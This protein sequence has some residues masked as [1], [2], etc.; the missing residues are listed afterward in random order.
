M[1]LI[2]I[3]LPVVILVAIIMGKK[4]PYIGGKTKLGFLLGG[5]CALILGG[6]MNPARW[7]VAWFWQFNGVAFANF[8]IIIG[9]LFAS[10]VTASG[11]VETIVN[12]L[13]SIFGRSSQG[14]VLVALL[15]SFAV[16]SMVG[17][18][19]AIA[20]VVGVIMIPAMK[21]LK[22]PSSLIV[23]I[24]VCGA[25]MG[26]IMPPVS[27][28][29]VQAMSYSGLS[30]DSATMI[31]YATVAVGFCLTSL[32]ICKI[33]VGNQYHLDASLIPEEKAGA[34][35]RREWSNLIPFVV[36]I[37]MILLASLPGIKIDI[38][39]LM[40]SLI[41]LGD[42]NLYTAWQSIPILGAATNY[43]VLD[44]AVACICCVATS[45]KVRMEIKNIIKSSSKSSFNVL[46]LT[47]CMVY[48]V[49]GYTEG[50][51]VST[52]AGYCTAVSGTTA[53]LL[54]AA[55]L[56][57]LGATTSSQAN[58]VALLVPAL[59]PVFLQLGVSEAYIIVAFAHLAYSG[60]LLPPNDV[61]VYSICGIFGPILG[62]NDL[63]DS[64]KVMAYGLPFSVY[65][66]V[67]GTIFL[68]L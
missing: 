39:K 35:F 54:G 18:V 24:I 68:F 8:V 22:M 57:L 64:Q 53:K 59:T 44:L 3:L 41:P 34:I 52:I 51:Q 21:D 49:M 25:S 30:A 9:S 38:M 61:N 67:V 29:L 56:L 23:A 37:V 12:I 7:A 11:G 26:S 58:S 65:L 13:R 45:K 47:S 62:D 40:I 28:A 2:S 55:L 32:V 15:A 5:L 42:G 33:Y 60:Q 14:I 48:F 17:T 66:G 46:L 31:T 10:M 1:K 6:C 36:L 43:I 27:N 63:V 4:I 19:V 16:G 50:G 20:A